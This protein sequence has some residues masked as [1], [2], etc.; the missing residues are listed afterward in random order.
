MF[1]KNVKFKDFD[2]QII[3]T[4]L[5]IYQAVSSSIVGQIV[6]YGLTPELALKSAKLSILKYYAMVSIYPVIIY[7]PFVNCVL[8][9][10]DQSENIFN[11]PYSMFDNLSL[12]H[13]KVLESFNQF[14]ITIDDKIY[15]CKAIN[16]R[17]PDKLRYFQILDQ[18]IVNTSYSCTFENNQDEV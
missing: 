14:E 13:K 18:S 5:K 9:A 6:D 2:I 4:S 12:R 7:Q 1:L 10:N 11:D 15:H 17:I 16:Y 8:F 3:E